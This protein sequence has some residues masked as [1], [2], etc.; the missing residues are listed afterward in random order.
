[1]NVKKFKVLSSCLEAIFKCLSILTGL[2]AII[3]IIGIIFGNIKGAVDFTGTSVEK[4][5]H[6]FYIGNGNVTTKIKYVA[7]AT[8]GLVKYL[9]LSYTYWHIGMFFLT[10]KQSSQPFTFEIYKLLKKIGFLLIISD[11]LAPLVYYANVSFLMTKGMEFSFLTITSQT[12]IGFIVYYFSEV[13]RYG[14]T[15]QKFSDDAV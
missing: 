3:L 2:L 12:L 7:R 10:L 8:S 11:I 15:L 13:I 9:L 5:F 6:L 1:M 4:G 14:M